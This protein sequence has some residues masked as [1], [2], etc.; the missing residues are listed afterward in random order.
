[1]LNTSTG[2]FLAAKSLIR[3][4]FDLGYMNIVSAS[5]SSRGMPGDAM[6]ITL[7]DVLHYQ[8]T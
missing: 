1:M 7:F 2:L 8:Y 4:L 6:S 3:A 5:E